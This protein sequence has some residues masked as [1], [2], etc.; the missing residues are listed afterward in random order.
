MDK[1]EKYIQKH[2]D[3]FDDQMPDSRHKERFNEKL[4]ARAPRT[5][6]VPLWQNVMKIASLAVVLIV[7]GTIFLVNYPFNSPK[8]AE[9]GVALSEVSPEYQE[10]ESYLQSNLKNKI[11]EFK[12]MECPEGDVEKEEVLNEISRLDTMYIE[13]QKDL[14]KNQGNERI[15]N[16]MINTYQTRIEILDQVI[17]QV[18]TN[19]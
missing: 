2:K 7:A 13:L 18:K 11:S 3:A 4:K 17:N 9:Q 8:A 1:L 16:A 14:K 12:S 19:C 6:T 5:K 10:V 15:I